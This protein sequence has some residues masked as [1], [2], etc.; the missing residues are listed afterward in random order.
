MVEVTWVSAAN[1]T[2]GAALERC[3]IEWCSATQKRL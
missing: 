3:G 1:S 2:S